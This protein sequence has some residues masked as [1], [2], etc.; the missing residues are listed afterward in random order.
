MCSILKL[1][2]IEKTFKTNYGN[3]EV[4]KVDLFINKGGYNLLGESGS[5]KVHY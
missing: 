1:F 4:L 3:K 5:G 2:N